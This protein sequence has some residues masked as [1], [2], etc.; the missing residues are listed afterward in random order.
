[1]A[2]DIYVAAFREQLGRG[3]LKGT[4]AQEKISEAL[5][6]LTGANAAE[7][8]RVF[9][10][11]IPVLI[12]QIG[13]RSL[14]L[15]NG[16]I[17]TSKPSGLRAIELQNHL[18]SIAQ[19]IYPLLLGEGKHLSEEIKDGI[20]RENYA[21]LITICK[22]LDNAATA[23]DADPE[24]PPTTP[25]ERAEIRLTNMLLQA[26][27]AAYPQMLF[28]TFVTKYP[29]SPRETEGEDPAAYEARQRD[30][31]L[32]R[33][34]F[35]RNFLTPSED[36]VKRFTLDTLTREPTATLSSDFTEHAIETWAK[37]LRTIID[38]TITPFILMLEKMIEK[39]VEPEI[40]IQIALTKMESLSS[41]L[42]KAHD[43]L[44]LKDQN[45]GLLV[46]DENT[47][48]G[49]AREALMKYHREAALIEI[50]LEQR[51]RTENL[52]SRLANAIETWATP[53]IPC[54]TGR[55]LIASAISD[56]KQ[57][58][59]Q[60]FFPEN[61]GKIQSLLNDLQNC[62]EPLTDEVTAFNP[63]TKSTNANATLADVGQQLMEII[64]TH[65][66]IMEAV[67]MQEEEK[68]TPEKTQEVPRPQTLLQRLGDFFK[69][70]M[71]WKTQKPANLET[72][73][74]PV[75]PI[76]KIQM[77]AFKAE[78][79]KIGHSPPPAAASTGY[80]DTDDTPTP[81]APGLHS[82]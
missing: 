21:R 38:D 81:P 30:N 15:T 48:S 6:D 13:E 3:F 35:N 78:F 29:A 37:T 57:Y 11:M 50:Y 77:A 55:K 27:L 22:T 65:T 14:A 16:L 5:K 34:E 17:D 53:I 61:K 69:S 42:T 62:I 54:A 44:S 32:K 1:M 4:F 28:E 74:E 76:R 26:A 20:G 41:A 73:A 19:A 18:L 25:D 46:Y 49:L 68:R 10:G 63:P 36:Y 24:M 9:E 33:G 67:E 72:A 43:S 31:A 80:D 58:Q 70:L 59:Q 12:S 39:K 64:E 40:A 51:Q 56:L 66:P 52:D 7:L 82:E 79:A 23:T 47:C 2:D 8:T 45:T 71:C 75:Q 60:C